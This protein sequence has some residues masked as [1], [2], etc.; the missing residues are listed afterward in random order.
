MMQKQ[1]KKIE[2]Q[3]DLLEQKQII[4]VVIDAVK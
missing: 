2:F 3:I 1:D 4:V